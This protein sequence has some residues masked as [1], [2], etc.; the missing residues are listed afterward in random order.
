[1]KNRQQKQ[2]NLK[3]HTQQRYNEEIA[4]ELLKTIHEQTQD[5]KNKE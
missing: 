4:E 5:K 1:M 2:Q 3:K